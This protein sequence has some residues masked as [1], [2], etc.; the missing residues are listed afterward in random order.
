MAPCT[1]AV[2]V[3]SADGSDE[4]LR[5]LLRWL[6]DE[7]DLRGK[8]DVVSERLQEGYMGGFVE[9]LSVVL[10]SSTISTFV[11]S[12]FDWLAR[13]REIG[14]VSVTVD[15]EQIEITAGSAGD[16]E[17]LLAAFRRTVDHG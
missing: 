9:V 3:D 11:S 4:E 15:G 8:V 16:A 14:K 5:R 2:E 10:T 17:R 7:D 6:R 12:L 1:V 13:R